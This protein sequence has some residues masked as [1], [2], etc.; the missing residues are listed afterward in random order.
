MQVY[1]P[2][3]Y[4]NQ[5]QVYS[6]PTVQLSG[7]TNKLKSTLKNLCYTNITSEIEAILYYNHTVTVHY[8][9]ILKLALCYTM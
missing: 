9:A 2:V 3:Q 1:L 5:S 4:L 6:L 7:N 8:L